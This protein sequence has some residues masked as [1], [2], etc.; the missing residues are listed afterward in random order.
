VS[1]FN[2]SLIIDL[3]SVKNITG[4]ATQ[5]RTGSKQFVQEYTIQVNKFYSAFLKAIYLANLHI[6]IYMFPSS[7]SCL[8]G[9]L[10]FC[11]FQKQFLF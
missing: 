1:D 8:K 5:G 10:T 2:Q 4:I 6:S 11:Y 9:Q 3:G 7:S